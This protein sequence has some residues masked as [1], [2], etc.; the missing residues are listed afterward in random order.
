MIFLLTVAV[1]LGL[2]ASNQKCW[3]FDCGVAF[4]VLLSLLSRPAGSKAQAGSIAAWHKQVIKM[5]T[6]IATWTSRQ[7][8]HAAVGYP[9]ITLLTCLEADDT[10]A[11]YTETLLDTLHRQLKVGLFCSILKV[12]NQCRGS[13]C[14]GLS[15]Y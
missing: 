12:R 15:D 7:S 13:G 4:I 5:R 10:F 8:K 6:E 14:S 1:F 9:L 2:L 3:A 11:A